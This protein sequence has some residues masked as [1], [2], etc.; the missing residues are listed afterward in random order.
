MKTL[1]LKE[2]EQWLETADLIKKLNERNKQLKQD[3][4]DLF[5][6]SMGEAPKSTSAKSNVKGVYLNNGGVRAATSTMRGNP[7]S[8]KL[9]LHKLAKT[10]RRTIHKK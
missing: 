6:L 4:S 10:L 9:K 8:V 7:L 1:S 2:R 3:M 5:R